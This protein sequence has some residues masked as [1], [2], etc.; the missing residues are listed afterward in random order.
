MT[1]FW[2]KNPVVILIYDAKMPKLLPTP[3]S[4][5]QANWILEDSFGLLVGQNKLFEVELDKAIN[6]K[7][8]GNYFDHFE[9]KNDKRVTVPASQLWTFA[10]SFFFVLKQL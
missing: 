9:E 3:A 5:I 1:Y 10:F 4:Q 6:R 2:N 8:I 7:F